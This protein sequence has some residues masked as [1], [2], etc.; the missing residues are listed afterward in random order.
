VDL[1]DY[2]ALSERAS[3]PW[4]PNPFVPHP[5]GAWHERALPDVVAGVTSLLDRYHRG[6]VAERQLLHGK[7]ND[8]RVNEAGRPSCHDVLSHWLYYQH[9]PGDERWKLLGQRYW[10][11]DAWLAWRA[12]LLDTPPSRRFNARDGLPHGRTFPKRSTDHER[13]LVSE[14]VI[15]KTVIQ[16]RLLVDRPEVETWLSRNL[17]CVVTRAQDRRLAASSHPDPADPWLRYRHTDIVL[18]HNPA[19]TEAEIEPLLRHGLVDKQ[20]VN[21]LVDKAVE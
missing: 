4:E 14:H 2:L 15:P 1:T 16:Q 17:C 5:D 3:I 8:R 6:E 19:W 13:G 9:H 12:K 7:D 20:S 18:L 10:S 21:P 11:V